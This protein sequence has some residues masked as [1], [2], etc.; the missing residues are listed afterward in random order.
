MHYKEMDA[1]FGNSMATGNF[2][3]DSSAALGRT[4]DEDDSQ[5]EEEEVTGHTT[6]GA[7]SSTTRTSAADRPNKK[8]KVIDLEQEGLISVFKSVG[9]N[10]AEAIRSAAKPEN[11]VPSD[12]FEVL[13][14]FP[15]FQSMHVSA[16]HLHLCSNP[17]IARSFYNL[18]YENQLHWFTMFVCDKFPGYFPTV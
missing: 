18:P 9:E 4:D 6:Q 10:I 3:K 5:D 12:L 7:T 14:T 1:I 16:Y 17:V 13:N 8:A 15:G 2:A 11:E